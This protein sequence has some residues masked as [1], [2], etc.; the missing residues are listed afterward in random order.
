M[1]HTVSDWR[2]D[3]DLLERA[4]FTRNVELGAQITIGALH[5]LRAMSEKLGVPMDKIT[6]EHIIVEFAQED[7]QVRAFK[8]HLTKK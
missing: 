1:K 6:A 2:K 8:K 7:A 3:L 4:N 5:T